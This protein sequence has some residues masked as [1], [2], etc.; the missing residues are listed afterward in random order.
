MKH[1]TY[2]IRVHVDSDSWEKL[3]TCNKG[4][5][6][7]SRCSKVNRIIFQASSAGFPIIMEHPDISRENGIKPDGIRGK[8]NLYI[9]H[10]RKTKCPW[11]SLFIASWKDKYLH[12][13]NLHCQ[14]TRKRRFDFRNHPWMYWKAGRK[15]LV[16]F[17]VLLTLFS[18]S[19]S[20]FL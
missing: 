14:P 15:L 11:F 10:I 16:R 8:R 12:A 7:I 13:T 17:L 6:R 19:F 1:S 9:G 18:L 3:S 5:G 2:N 20:I 4:T